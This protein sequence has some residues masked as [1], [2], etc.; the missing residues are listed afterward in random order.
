MIF[1]N[2]LPEEDRK[3][4]HKHLTPFDAKRGEAIYHGGSGAD[5][6]FF[7][8][9]G[10]VRLLSEQTKEG[11]SADQTFS[12]LRAEDFFG[13]EAIIGEKNRYQHT[14]KALENTRLQVLSRKAFEDMMADSIPGGTRV[15]LEISR[16]YR[17]VLEDP[18]MR[19][20]VVLFYGP[21]DG[22]GRTTLAINTAIMLARHSQKPVAY[23]D[24]DFQLG[25]ASQTLKGP[26]SPNISTLIQTEVKL[27]LDRIKAAMHTHHGVDFLWGPYLPQDAEI[28]TRDALRRILAELCRGYAW[29]VVE[30]KSHID[31]HTLQLW[32]RADRFLLVG[33]PDLGFF[34]RLQRLMRLFDSLGYNLER[35]EGV[36]TLTG[37]DTAE[38]LDQ[39][40]KVL[41]R[42]VFTFH[43]VPLLSR[44]AE[45][46]GQPLVLQAPDSDYTRD[47]EGFVHSLLGKQPGAPK[48]GGI[49]ARLASFF[50]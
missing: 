22:G 48:Q 28:I 30:C 1:L 29:V 15:L 33:T 20:K 38:Y 8:E 19:G 31:D 3:L 10:S 9:S 14:A 45:V 35:F 5:A 7:I 26:R 34:D 23:L 13:E 21:R 49:F 44:Q 50:G 32:D 17:E 24:A 36:L 6:M 25:N 37:A 16:S 4:L 43:S 27:S 41:K 42:P 12:I 40:R 2:R 46:A 47:V 18:E 39:F 11:G